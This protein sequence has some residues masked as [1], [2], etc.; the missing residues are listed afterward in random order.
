MQFKTTVRF[1]LTLIRMAIIKNLQIINAGE[2]VEKRE[3]S[4]AIGGNINWC[5]HMENS[6]EGPQKSKN[7]ATI[8]STNPIPGHISRKDKN[9]NSKRYQHPNVHSS[10][11]YNSQDMETTHAK[12]QMIG[13][14]RCHIYIYIYIYT[15]T[16]IY[17]YKMEYY[18]V[19]KK[20][21]ILTFAQHG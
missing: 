8:W 9:S 17:T 6:M 5:S 15:H 20:N 19:I 16:H 11:I 2:G 10:T 7:R 4:Y 12:Q 3:P 14:R 18:S 13:L 1:H 21:E